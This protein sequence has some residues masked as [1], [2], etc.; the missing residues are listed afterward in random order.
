MYPQNIWRETMPQ[1][2]PINPLVFEFI[3]EKLYYLSMENKAFTSYH[4]NKF[5]KF[6]QIK[7]NA[8]IF[9]IHI[10]LMNNYIR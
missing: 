8:L 3:Y 5:L 2:F 10:C 6:Q 7:L 1:Q 4:F 9:S